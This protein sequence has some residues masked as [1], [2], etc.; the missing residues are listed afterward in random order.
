M[1]D[2]TWH[3]LGIEQGFLAAMGDVNFICFFS[4]FQAVCEN[5]SLFYFLIHKKVNFHGSFD[6]AHGVGDFGGVQN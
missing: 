6:A 2:V 4:F 5:I 3:S 1:A